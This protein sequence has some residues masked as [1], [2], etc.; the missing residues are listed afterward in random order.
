MTVGTGVG[1]FVSGL[2]L[3]TFFSALGLMY[4]GLFR[5]VHVE[6][7]GNGSGVACGANPGLSC[8]HTAAHRTDACEAVEAQRTPY[9]AIRF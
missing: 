5:C 4:A 9:V 2:D 3:S 8:S 7:G 1:A 6:F